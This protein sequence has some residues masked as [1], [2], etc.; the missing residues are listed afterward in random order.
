MTKL[1]ITEDGRVVTEHT[2]RKENIK[3]V[4][5]KDEIDQSGVGRVIARA[6][7]LWPLFGDLSG[8]RLDRGG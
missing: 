8:E 5:G 4:G 3:L 2:W 1:Y 7:R 6:S